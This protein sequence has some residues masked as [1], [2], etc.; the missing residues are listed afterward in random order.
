MTDTT[1][2]PPSPGLQTQTQSAFVTLNLITQ[3]CHGVLNTTFIAPSP[4]PSWFADL[5]SKL[6]TAK[7]QATEWIDNLA[8]NVTGGVPV[9]VIDYGT[10]YSAISE[11][12]N[13]IVQANP[14]A[15]GATDPNV[16][17]VHKLVSALEQQVQTILANVQATQDSLKNWGDEM[18]SSHDAL[19]TGAANI[20]SA[21]ASLSADIDKMNDA[22]TQLNKTIHQEN[23]AIAA[24]ASG[25][26]LGLILLVAGV[27]LAPETGG[28]SLLVAGTGGILII[29]GS[30]TWGIM[31]SKI[32]EQ[33]NEVAQ[34]QAEL[35]D[36]NR[37]LVALQGLASSSSQAI[38]YIANA[39]SALSD[40]RTSWTVFQGELQGV[41][42]KL[43]L[44]EAALSTIVE[45]VFTQAAS[46]EW[47][48]ATSF[49]QSLANAPVQVASQELPLQQAA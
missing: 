28:A 2:M 49:A 1:S 14:N 36:D 44:A 27:A 12:I 19:T 29:G 43:Q 39:D 13:A 30:V 38:A 41:L 37:Q 8:P 31:Q 15:Q 22:I 5:N 11:S 7:T 46:N 4:Q 40:F 6:D 33:F 16:I 17:Q 23:I 24:S 21:E 32:N 47:A 48:L 35:S 45:G 18:Q 26:G 10:T 9:Q 42:S 25:I 3:A 34:D 20:Q